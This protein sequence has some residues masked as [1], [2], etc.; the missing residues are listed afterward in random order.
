MSTLLLYGILV[1]AS[2]AMLLFVV[3]FICFQLS[4]GM[5]TTL[6]YAVAGK[7]LLSAFALL[8]ISAII[9][10][11]MVIAQELSAY[12]QQDAAALRQ[13]L[14]AHTRRQHLQQQAEQEN[15]QLAY[16]QRMKRLRLLAAN[17]RKHL[18]SLYIAIHLELQA[19][20][21]Q[22]PANHYATMRKT[23]RQYHKRA[24]A[25]AMLALRQ[26]ILCR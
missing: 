22:L 24:D 20:K 8:L 15:R 25:K 2:L 5:L 11:L 13:V 21:A 6:F 16:V 19:I 26:Q 9:T 10:A 23:L 3:G 4:L 18:R 14:A 12:F 7:M 1:I 17:D